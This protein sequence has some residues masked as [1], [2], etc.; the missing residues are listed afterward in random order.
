MN[1]SRGQLTP[2]ESSGKRQAQQSK[3]WPGA[4]AD[5]KVGPPLNEERPSA[6]A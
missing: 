6:S 5:Q 3:S 4:T 2:L 1:D